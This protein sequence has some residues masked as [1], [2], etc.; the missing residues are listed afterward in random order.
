M[1]TK[2]EDL[3]TDN[4]DSL[5]LVAQQVTV[6]LIH[7]PGPLGIQLDYTAES[8]IAITRLL[9]PNAPLRFAFACDARVVHKRCIST[10]C[11]G[12]WYLE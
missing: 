3:I 10:V 8:V 7:P 5:L 6:S 11:V 12:L 2:L 4:S 1:S 9:D